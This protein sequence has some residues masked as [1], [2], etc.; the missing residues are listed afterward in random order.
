MNKNYDYYLWEDFKKGRRSAL[1]IIFDKYVDLLY[2]LGKRFSYTDEFIKESIQALFTDLLSYRNVLSSTDNVLFTL[3][4]V[5]RNKI[6]KP[7]AEAGN[8][9]FFRRFSNVLENATSC[10]DEVFSISKAYI[11]NNDI[12]IG[13]NLQQ[14][15]SVQNEI[16][17]Y[18]LICCFELE[19]ISE[20]LSIQSNVVQET[21]IKT[22]KVIYENVNTLEFV[23]D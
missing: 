6:L 17:F 9:Q 13:E 15:D 5:Y 7:Y 4:K 14:L 22:T 20:I 8:Q 12:A 23:G 1:D 21:L 11:Q 16:M 10:N 3:L 19:Q 18:R 2:I